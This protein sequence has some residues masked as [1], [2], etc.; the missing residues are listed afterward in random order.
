MAAEAAIHPEF[1]ASHETAVPV[2]DPRVTSWTFV[3]PPRHSLF[4]VLPPAKV[5]LLAPATS[6][7]EDDALVEDDGGTGAKGSDGGG[8][9]APT[10]AQWHAVP[11]SYGPRRKLHPHSGIVFSFQWAFVVICCDELCHYFFFFFYRHA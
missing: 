4:D 7:D 1:R 8:G 5:P 6:S 3:Y 9:Q 11:Q 2:P 10:S